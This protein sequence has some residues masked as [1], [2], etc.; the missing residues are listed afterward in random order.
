LTDH[1]ASCAVD[2]A[3]CQFTFMGAQI[4]GYGA[5]PPVSARSEK[6]SYPED[7]DGILGPTQALLNAIEAFD[8]DPVYGNQAEPSES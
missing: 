6:L 8:R 7:F 3:L 1:A 5:G 4:A 2:P